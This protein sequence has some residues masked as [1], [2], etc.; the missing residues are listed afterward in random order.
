MELILIRHADA[1]AAAGYAEDA[2]RPLTQKGR[3]VQEHV[4]GA[5]NKMGVRPDR[6]LCSPR[7][8]AYQTAE[9]TALGLGGDLPEEHGVLDGG[10]SVGQLVEAL[11]AYPTGTLICVGH[12]PDMSTWAAQLLATDAR[13]QV[14]FSKSG[15]LGLSFPAHP[16][17]GAATLEYFYRAADLA[18]LV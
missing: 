14:H 17:P 6:V 18:R 16:A 8:R 5:L 4:T 1:E 7:V 9:I 11:R 15:V 13:L 2:L 3:K 12:E 10:H